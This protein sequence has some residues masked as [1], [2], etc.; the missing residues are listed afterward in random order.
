[1]MRVFIETTLL[2]EIKPIIY[3]K[4]K[5]F[6]CINV[7]DFLVGKRI[8]EKSEIKRMSLFKPSLAKMT[9]LKKIRG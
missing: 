2:F 6:V 7:I 8:L 4:S 3:N 5:F 9:N 1:M